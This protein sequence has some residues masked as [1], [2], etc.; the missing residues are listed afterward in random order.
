MDVHPGKST[1]CEWYDILFQLSIF[2]DAKNVDLP[3]EG[4]QKCIVN[5]IVHPSQRLEL[6]LYDVMTKIM[7]ITVGVQSVNLEDGDNIG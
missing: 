4:A 6:S 2:S 5:P 1:H 3:K 7:S